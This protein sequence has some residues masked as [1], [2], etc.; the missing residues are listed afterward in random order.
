MISDLREAIPL[1]VRLTKNTTA[2]RL[3]AKKASVFLKEGQTIMLDGSTTAA[4]LLPHIASFKNV[5]VYTN[6]MLTAGS[7]ISY[8]IRTH[9]I[10]GCSVNGSAVLSGEEAYRTVNRLS[11]DILFFSSQSI[12]SRGDISD[13][14]EEENYLRSLM[15]ERT[16]ETVFLCDS[17]KFNKSSLHKLVNISDVDAAVFDSPFD[18]LRGKCKKIIL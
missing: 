17:E 16:S 1:D 13:S 15:L 3:I 11:P 4:F 12:D 5:T 2:K 8:G 6:S 18:E 10:G 14:T 7:S 9:C